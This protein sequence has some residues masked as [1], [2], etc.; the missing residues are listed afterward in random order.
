MKVFNS[1]TTDSKDEIMEAF[2]TVVAKG[3]VDNISLNGHVTGLLEDVNRKKS[4][5]LSWEEE[6]DLSK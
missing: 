2:A 5:T 4:F 1:I 6:K 3:G